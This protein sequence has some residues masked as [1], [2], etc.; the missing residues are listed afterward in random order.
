MERFFIWG[1]IFCENNIVEYV[2]DYYDFIP[3]QGD[4]DE[5]GGDEAIPGINNPGTEVWLPRF[6]LIGTKK[7]FDNIEKGI[8]KIFPGI[9]KY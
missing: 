8:K 7:E 2:L 6:W 3:S 4:W 9:E 5:P 1:W